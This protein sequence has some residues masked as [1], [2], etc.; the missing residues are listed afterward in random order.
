MRLSLI[1]VVMK[2]D[3]GIVPS[4]TMTHERGARVKILVNTENLSGIDSR[5]S[6]FETRGPTASAMSTV[7]PTTLRRAFVNSRSIVLRPSRLVTYLVPRFIACFPRLFLTN[8]FQSG[9]FRS[10]LNVLY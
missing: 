7:P 9:I 1:D 6:S 10:T 8:D 4:E 5:S 2:D 3:K